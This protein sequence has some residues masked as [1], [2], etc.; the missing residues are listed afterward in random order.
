MVRRLHD[1]VL[2]DRRL[3]FV[4]L[5][6]AV[7]DEYLGIAAG[8][9]LGAVGCLRV[10]GQREVENDARLVLGEGFLEFLVISRIYGRQQPGREEERSATVDL[11]EGLI[12]LPQDRSEV[13][14]LAV[15]VLAH[16]L[17]PVAV[18]DLEV[19]VAVRLNPAAGA[20]IGLK[21]MED[22]VV[23]AVTDLEAN[24]LHY[25]E[26]GVTTHEPATL[27][28]RLAD[29]IEA[30][31]LESGIARPKLLGVGIGLAG[32]VSSYDGVVYSSPF[33]GW[34]D[35]PLANLVEERL[36]LPVFLDNDV[37]TLTFA[38]Q[39]FGPGQ[40]TS[41]FVV[42]TVGR[43]IGMGM[44]L[45]DEVY[46]G[47]RGGVGEIGHITLDPAGPRCD[48]GKTG[49]LEALAS[50]PAVV[51]YMQD[52]LRRRGE[53][54]TALPTSLADV[55]HAAEA[56]D[57]LAHEALTRSG[58]YLGIG[59]ATAVNILCPSLIILSGEGVVAGDY[60][61]KPMFDALKAHTFNGLLQG[62]EIVVQRTDDRAWAR[63]AASLVIGKVFA[64][65]RLDAEAL[66]AV[67]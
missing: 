43:G 21:L 24:V 60:R 26:W 15:D 45:N 28:N 63:G 47:V 53:P 30:L 42:I 27:S 6:Q 58:W 5:P 37:N 38:E 13:V 64:S 8:Q 41:D 25:G 65:P 51:A 55:I 56:G 12:D 39:L 10:G 16:D 4:A 33:L 49:C 34:R 40:H 18:S 36:G 59:I 23:G 31:I 11:V 14:S 35:V 48:C 44:V 22:R 46:E 67:P 57:T 52:G 9:E 54:E 66:E 50:D 29:M 1:V 61:L 3:V 2:E 19:L 32:A 7:P 17:D 62:V 20:V